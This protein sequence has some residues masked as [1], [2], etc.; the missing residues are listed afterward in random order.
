MG[1][2]E[3]SRSMEQTEQ[4]AEQ[5]RMFREPTEELLVLLVWFSTT[6]RTVIIPHAR[7]NSRS[8]S[9]VLL[10]FA[11]P[12]KLLSNFPY[13]PSPCMAIKISWQVPR[14][15][16]RTQGVPFIRSCRTFRGSLLALA[17]GHWAVQTNFCNEEPTFKI[18]VWLAFGSRRQVCSCFGLEAVHPGRRHCQRAKPS[19]TSSPAVLQYGFRYLPE[20]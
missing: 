12:E 2:P 17:L 4:L 15:T 6:R 13:L 19:K 14:R 11:Q 16:L 7:C 10:L 1:V 9:V 20:L 5:D 18:N 8:L 3:G